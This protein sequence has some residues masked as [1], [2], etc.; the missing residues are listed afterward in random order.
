MFSRTIWLEALNCSHVLFAGERF[1]SIPWN[2]IPEYAKR[3]NLPQNEQCS[4]SKKLV[5]I[6]RWADL[7][8]LHCTWY[9]K[10]DAVFPFYYVAQD[11]FIG[12]L[13]Y[14]P[15]FPYFSIQT[16]IVYIHMQFAEKYFMRLTTKNKFIC[17]I[18][19]RTCL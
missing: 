6:W 16:V 19:G 13:T 9:I 11:V 2:V 17:I 18:T 1:L 4:M 15:S 10:R 8:I 7:N 5:M 12:I 3:W 14:I